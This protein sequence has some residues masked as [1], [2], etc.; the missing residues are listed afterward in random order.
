MPSPLPSW[1]GVSYVTSNAFM[2]T[3]AGGPP[4][5]A[6]AATPVLFKDD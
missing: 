4:A 1:D 6:T 5:G 3:R 2:S